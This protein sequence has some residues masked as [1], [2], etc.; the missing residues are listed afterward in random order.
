MAE[1][2]SQQPVI[3]RTKYPKRFAFIDKDGYACVADRSGGR[4]SPEDLAKG[5]KIKEHQ[6]KLR[7]RIFAQK[8]SIRTAVQEGKTDA[9]TKGAIELQKANGALKAFR[10]LNRKQKLS[11]LGIA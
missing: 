5:V 2:V 8:K 11:E 4:R 7:E 10:S 6:R 1:R 3:D 9:V